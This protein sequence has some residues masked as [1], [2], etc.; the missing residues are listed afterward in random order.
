MQ[1]VKRNNETTVELFWEDLCSET[2]EKLMEL[3]GDHGNYDVI[4]FAILNIEQ[5]D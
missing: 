5:E 2:Q 4:P 3:M 1:I